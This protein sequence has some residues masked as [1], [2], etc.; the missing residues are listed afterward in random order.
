MPG[1][2][3]GNPGGII[4]KGIAGI[5]LGGPNSSRMPFCFRQYA[6]HVISFSP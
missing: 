1:G 3:G 5:V 2:I 4:G 6:R